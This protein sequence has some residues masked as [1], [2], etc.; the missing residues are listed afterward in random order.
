MTVIA[1]IMAAVRAVPL[2]VEKFDQLTAAVR[3]FRDKLDDRELE[4]IKEQ[5][6]DLSSRL[7]NE[8]DKAELNR[9]VTRFNKL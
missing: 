4:E 5:L 9:I 1:D 7:R 6:N 2:L 8:T 3:D